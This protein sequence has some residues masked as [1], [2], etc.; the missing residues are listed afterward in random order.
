MDTKLGGPESEPECSEKEKKY[1]DALGIES[2]FPD[3]A[4]YSQISILT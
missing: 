1:L 2:E 4:A 3:R